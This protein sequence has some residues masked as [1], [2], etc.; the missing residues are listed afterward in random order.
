MKKL[1]EVVDERGHP[2]MIPFH[3]VVRVVK[4]T[5]QWTYAPAVIFEMDG[6]T[7][8]AIPVQEGEVAWGAYRE[9]VESL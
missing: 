5:S 9:W 6:G 4:C 8:I 7:Q 2:T 1:F 3:R